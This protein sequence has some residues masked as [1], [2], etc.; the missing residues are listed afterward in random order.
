MIRI[1]LIV[2]AKGIHKPPV[3]KPGNLTLSG[4][5]THKSF[6]REGVGRIPHTYVDDCGNEVSKYVKWSALSASKWK[7]PPCEQFINLKQQADLGLQ[8]AKKLLPA[9]RTLLNMP[10]FTPQYLL[11]ENQDKYIADIEKAADAAGFA[12]KQLPNESVRE[13]GNRIRKLDKVLK[14]NE[15]LL[16]ALNRSCEE[17]KKQS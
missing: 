8:P 13:Y 14:E 5:L 16:R 17:E 10:D 7:W 2:Q 4:F 9:E 15:K 1:S 6:D 11:A 12:L 3:P